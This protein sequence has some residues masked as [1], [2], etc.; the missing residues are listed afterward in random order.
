MRS[1]SDT[2]LRALE[3]AD[4]PRGGVFRGVVGSPL[5]SRAIDTVVRTA[6][7]EVCAGCGVSGYWI[8]PICDQGA[9]RLLFDAVCRRCGSETALG[10]R[11]DRCDAWTSSITACRSA[12]AF[13]GV[14]RTTI[15]RLKYQGEYA[16]SEWC[17]LQIARLVIE[18]DWQ[19]DLI[20]PVPLHRTRMRTRGYN[21]SAKIANVTARLL[22][23]PA[24]S[25]LVRTRATQSQVGLDGEGRR[26]NV[27]GAF[28]CPYDLTDLS[29]L[30][31][32]DVV[33]TGATLD[34]CSI[35]L[36]AAGANDVWATTVATG[37]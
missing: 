18:L 32:D 28:A 1:A 7:P 35:A 29:V 5:V 33:T 6:F 13:D 34:A 30:L 31:I 16:R 27:D 12:Y 8:C 21:Q 22:E 10:S 23:V 36:R 4:P 2:R 19:P 17:G 25:V 24:G 14:V 37:S 11:C 20:V 3:L 9:R 26:A 15:H